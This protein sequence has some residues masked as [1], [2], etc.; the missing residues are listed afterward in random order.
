MPWHGACHRGL[1]RA[2]RAD[3]QHVVDDRQSRLA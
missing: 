3:H 2:R 1:A